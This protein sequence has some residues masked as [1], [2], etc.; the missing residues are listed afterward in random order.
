MRV[1]LGDLRCD[2]GPDDQVRGN[3]VASGVAGLEYSVELAEG[4]LAIG[5]ERLGR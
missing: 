3:V 2:V 5:S 1:E 4:Q